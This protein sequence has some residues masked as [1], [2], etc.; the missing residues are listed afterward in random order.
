MTKDPMAAALQT[1]FE[2]YLDATFD[3]MEVSEAV[4]E[5]AALAFLYGFAA[6]E[7]FDSTFMT[8]EC[9]RIADKLIEDKDG[10]G[11]LTQ[12]GLDYLKEVKE[13]K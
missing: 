7:F 5:E 3:D 1:Y 6:D 13:A 12:K 4:K 2:G 9:E 11:R 10:E 8:A